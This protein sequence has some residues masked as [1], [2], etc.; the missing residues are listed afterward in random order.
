MSYGTGVSEADMPVWQA[1]IEFTQKNWLK[2]FFLLDEAQHKDWL[3]YFQTEKRQV[4]PI[5]FRVTELKNVA[6]KI[7]QISLFIYY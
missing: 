2:F 5:S 6:V 3:M 4:F 1:D 7:W